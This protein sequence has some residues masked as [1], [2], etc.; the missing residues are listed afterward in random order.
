MLLMGFAYNA[1]IKMQLLSVFFSLSI[2]TESRF[3]SCSYLLLVV[4]LAKCNFYH[5]FQVSVKIIAYF[6]FSMMNN[7]VGISQAVMAEV[8]GMMHDR[9]L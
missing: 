3:M 4:S 8:F 7:S 5:L 9:T 2:C 1:A 6:I